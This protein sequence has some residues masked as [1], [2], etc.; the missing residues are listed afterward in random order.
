MTTQEWLKEQNAAQIMVKIVDAHNAMAKIRDAA[1]QRMLVTDPTTDEGKE[2]EAVALFLVRAMGTITT[3]LTRMP[4]A[5]W[6]IM[7]EVP[8]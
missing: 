7:N 5:I 8:A 1:E 2:A 6:D 4:K 3:G